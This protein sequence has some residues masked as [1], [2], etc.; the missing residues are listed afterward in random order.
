MKHFV[1]LFSLLISINTFAQTEKFIDQYK[2][3][4]TY[5]ID[6]ESLELTPIIN[7]DHT[8][9]FHSYKTQRLINK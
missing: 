4:A 8:F 2:L 7:S 3:S 9:S 1:I 6:Q 5:N